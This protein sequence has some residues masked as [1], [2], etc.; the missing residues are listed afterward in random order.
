VG[1][2]YR[3]GTKFG[4]GDPQSSAL[5]GDSLKAEDFSNNLLEPLFASDE[6]SVSLSAANQQHQYC[7]D[8]NR[9]RRQKFEFHSSTS[10]SSL[11]SPS[12]MSVFTA[13]LIAAA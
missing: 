1:V 2:S 7:V 9:C 6:L 12:S 13:P 5:D 8:T 4:S 10:P 11:A 3:G